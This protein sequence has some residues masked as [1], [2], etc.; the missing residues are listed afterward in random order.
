MF[1]KKLKEEGKKSK[2]NGQHNIWNEK[3]PRRNQQQDNRDRRINKWC[4]RQSGRNNSH[5]IKWRKNC[6]KNWVESLRSMGQN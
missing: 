4:G 3:H 2:L 6:E 1:N 5:W